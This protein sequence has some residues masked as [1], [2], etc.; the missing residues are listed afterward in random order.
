MSKCE[1][2]DAVLNALMEAEKWYSYILGS[3]G[4]SI[5]VNTFLLN[6]DLEEIH[7]LIARLKR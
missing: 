2:K 7:N 5:T 3:K 1:T 4:L 6:A